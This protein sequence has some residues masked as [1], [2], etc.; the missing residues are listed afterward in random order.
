MHLQVEPGTE[1]ASRRLQ[2][3]TLSLAPSF[4]EPT[5]TGAQLSG[6]VDAG[7]FV[8][9]ARGVA[10]DYVDAV[11]RQIG[12]LSYTGEENSKGLTG[13]PVAPAIGVYSKPLC[14]SPWRDRQRCTAFPQ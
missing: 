9:N 10:V 8:T 1:P 11:V 2:V 3:C 13:I 14:T 7:T 4:V 6:T 5:S 12:G